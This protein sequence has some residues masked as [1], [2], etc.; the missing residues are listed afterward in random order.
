MMLKFIFSFF[1]VSHSGTKSKKG[2]TILID[3]P[4]C[5]YK[6]TGEGIKFPH[7]LE[8]AGEII[9]A[10]TLKIKVFLNVFFFFFLPK[11]IKYLSDDRTL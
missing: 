1:P 11:C 6:D 10:K 3:N 9:A 4:T 7:S 5:G 2:M 8:I